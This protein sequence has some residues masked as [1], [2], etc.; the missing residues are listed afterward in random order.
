MAQQSDQLVDI[1]TQLLDIQNRLQPVVIQGS[2]LHKDEGEAIGS[3]LEIISD[4]NGEIGEVVETL[5]ALLSSSVEQNAENMRF[6]LI[7]SAIS[8]VAN[9]DDICLPDVA[10][11]ANLLADFVLEQ[12]V[13]N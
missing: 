3:I 13:S 2:I 7:C 4:V 5:Q 1:A 8:G 11:R 10:D 6:Q 12:F 9:I